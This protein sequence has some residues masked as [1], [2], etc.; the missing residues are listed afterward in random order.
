L[1]PYPFY[2]GIGFAIAGLL[3]SW[4]LVKDTAP[5][6]QLETETSTIPHLRNVFWATTWKDNNLGSVSQAGMVNNLNDGMIWGLLPILLT[7]K[8]FNLTDT[9]K[10]VA[11]YPIVWGIGQLFTGKLA[12]HWIKKHML[13][14][15]MLI[16]G[17]AIIMMVWADT[18]T[19]YFVL[20]IILGIGTATV[21]P[22]FLASIADHTH[23]EQRANSIG[24]FRLWRD[25]G[26]AIGALLTGIVADAISIEWAVAA[27][28]LLTFLS[29]VVIQV[30]M[31]R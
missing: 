3:A 21:Y 28:G 23:P 22:T 24:V 20:A 17:L 7:V 19:E 13:F 30:R 8:E 12:D 18:F 10:V 9:G 29:A 6:V 25:L 14:W 4:F 27:V 2:L 11:I 5:H 16:Q 31:D 1:R 15:G 26:Y